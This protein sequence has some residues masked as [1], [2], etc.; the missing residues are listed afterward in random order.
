M[1]PVE[2]PDALRGRRASEPAAEESPIH[3]KHPALA[4]DLPA[5]RNEPPTDFAI[6]R[7]RK[8][9]REAL[10]EV[11][12]QMGRSYP[13]VI[14]GEDVETRA[15]IISRNPSDLSEAVGTVA[16]AE[17]QHAAAA[18]AAAKEALA[19]WSS[20]GAR[21]R[22]DFLLEAA[23]EMRRRRFELAA[24]E[25]YECGKGWREADGDVCEAIDF[26]VYYAR[27]AI[28]LEQ[29]QEVDVPGE[30]NRF[31]YMPRGV[32]AVISPWNFPLAILTGMT[33]AALA[34]GNTVIMKPAEQ[35]SVIAAKLMEIFR[36]IDLPPG[37]LQYLPGQG[38]VVGAAL[39]EHP[40]VALIAFTGSRGGAGHQCQGG[41]SF[42]AGHR[43]C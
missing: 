43:V 18:V 9:V 37:V 36:E 24:W 16:K 41:G 32:T 6:E 20:L 3:I 15:E 21:R 12:S 10:E 13:L 25:V 40:D 35:S 17:A 27:G 1:N 19:E 26:C 33:T 39:V 31:I 2:H 29:A 14:N 4:G 11:R 28:A 42:G 8:A 34:T 7:N 30:E 38:E 5:F 22:A 23:A